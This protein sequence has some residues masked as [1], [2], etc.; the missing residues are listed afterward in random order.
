MKRASFTRAVKMDF[1]SVLP[2]PV[3]LYGVSVAGLGQ[4]KLSIIHD[5]FTVVPQPLKTVIRVLVAL[6]EVLQRSSATK[7]HPSTA[8]DLQIVGGA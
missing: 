4:L 6:S 2:A 1:L 5:V 3:C 8:I 7:N